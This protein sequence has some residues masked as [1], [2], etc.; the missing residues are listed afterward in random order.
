MEEQDRTFFKGMVLTIPNNLEN[1]DKTCGV[2][3]SMRS[4][5]GQRKIIDEIYDNGRL[6][7]DGFIWDPKDFKASSPLK[8]IPIAHFDPEELVT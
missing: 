8:K 6:S 1:T 2:F 4:M 7:I 3:S 5:A